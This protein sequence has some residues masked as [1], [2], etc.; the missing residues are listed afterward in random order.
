MKVPTNVFF[1]ESDLREIIKQHF[2][3]DGYNQ[4]G[5]IEI[6]V[7]SKKEIPEGATAGDVIGINAKVEKISDVKHNRAIKEYPLSTLLDYE[8]RASW[9][10][11]L[12]GFSFGYELA[13]KY[14]AWKTSRKYARY[15]QSKIWEQRLK[16]LL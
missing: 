15:K 7:R 12:I 3:N 13:G 9:W 16:D 6:N 2:L 8:I 4:V 1:N 14:F 5:D 11:M 10:A